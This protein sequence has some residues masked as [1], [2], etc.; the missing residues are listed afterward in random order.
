MRSP[1]TNVRQG[2]TVVFRNNFKWKCE[3]ISTFVLMQEIRWTE[4]KFADK[5]V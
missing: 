3:G 1:G 2:V 4:T 5:L